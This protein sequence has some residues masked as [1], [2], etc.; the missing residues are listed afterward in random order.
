MRDQH[1]SD[2]ESMREARMMRLRQHASTL[3][4]GIYSPNTI[5]WAIADR[6]W[7]AF[8][9]GLLGSTTEHKLDELTT[10]ALEEQ[11]RDIQAGQGPEKDWQPVELRAH[12]YRVCIT[13]Y[14]NALRRGGQIK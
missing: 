12:R 8:R 3:T 6:E 1:G 14:V 13:N 9:I 10:L 5:A 4:F 11:C 2:N 7:Q